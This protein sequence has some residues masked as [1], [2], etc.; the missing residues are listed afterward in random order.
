MDSVTG[1]AVGRADVATGVGEGS[2]VVGASVN[3]AFTH[4]VRRR[5]TNQKA[6]VFLKCIIVISWKELFFIH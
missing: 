3:L 5:T 6:I 4:P 1:V 2:A